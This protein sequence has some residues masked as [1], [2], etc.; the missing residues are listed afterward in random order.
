ML[1]HTSCIMDNEW[2]HVLDALRAINAEWG[3]QIDLHQEYLSNLFEQFGDEDM[4]LIIEDMMQHLDAH[5]C[6]NPLSFSAPDFHETVRDVLHEYFEGTQAFE[7]SATMDLEADALCRFCEAQYFKWIVPAREC[8]STFIRKPPNVAVID[9]KLA[10]IRAKPQP[11]Q[12]TPDWYKFRHNLLTAS[13]AWKAFESE[14]CK[15]QLI[16]EKCKPLKVHEEKEYVNTSST[17][18]WGQKYEPVS[19]MIYEHMY[20]T[21]VADFGCLQHD[22]HAFLGASPDGINVDPASPL[23]GRM[24]EIKNIV[25]RDIT[26]IPKKEYWIQMQ[27]QMEVADLNECDFLETQ[28][29]EEGEDGYGNEN[30]NNEN[31]DAL[32]TGTIIY[33]MKNGKPHY[34]YEPIECPRSVS[35]AWFNEAME[36]NQ[37]HMWMKTIHW[38]LEK[39]SCVLVLRNKLWF[40]HAIGVLDG[41]WQTIVQERSNPQGYEHRAPKRR[42][43]AASSTLTPNTQTTASS[44]S[45][46]QAWLSTASPNPIERKC[47]IDMSSLE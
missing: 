37:A 15:N 25:N 8:G 32:L 24:V 41:L 34:E 23:Y 45:F 36:R 44:A 31:N 47:L 22:A 38:R 6:A 2:S 35:E 43:T 13:N 1:Q 11:D 29:S 46:M 21:K 19:R 9:A 27:L 10:H 39:M 4:L 17:L 7:F 40:Q 28:F 16:Y 33:F 30:D 42:I 12:R 20:K 14:A 26:G 18:H 5:I 3:Q